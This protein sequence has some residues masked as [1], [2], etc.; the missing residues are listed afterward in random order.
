[1]KFLLRIGTP[2][3][4]SGVRAILTSGAVMTRSYP[5]DHKA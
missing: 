1:V 5:R 4:I 2:P 3:Q